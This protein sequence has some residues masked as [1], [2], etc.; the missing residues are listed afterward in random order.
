MK[1]KSVISL[2]AA[3]LLAVSCGTSPESDGY[4]V[5]SVDEQIERLEQEQGEDKQEEGQ[6]SKQDLVAPV[7]GGAVAVIC[8]VWPGCRG[9]IKNGVI[10]IKD[11]TGKVVAVVKKPFQKLFKKSDGAAADTA[12]AADGT[13]GGAGK[14]ADGA[15]YWQNCGWR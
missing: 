12:K 4:T 13:G 11:G 8:A 10:K 6:D 3:M 9:V 15:G 1:F 2:V 7:T 5:A 14:T